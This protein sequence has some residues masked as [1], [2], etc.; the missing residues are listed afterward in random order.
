VIIDLAAEQGGNCELTVAGKDV[1]KHDVTVI[2]AVNVPAMVPVDSSQ[3][4]AK[5]ILNLF[6]YLYKKGVRVDF[7]DDIPK[8]LHHPER[9]I[10]NESFRNAF[11]AEGLTG[12]GRP[13]PLR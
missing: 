1:V 10:V 7:T 13:R 4:Y 2:G 11:T 6:Q 5:N 3:M 9:Q 8:V 12:A